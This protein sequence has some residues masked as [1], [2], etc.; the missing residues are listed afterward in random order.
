MKASPVQGEVGFAQQNSGGLS[1]HAADLQFL[2][3]DSFTIPRYAGAPFAQGSLFLFGAYAT[4]LLLGEPFIVGA[5]R[6]F[7]LLGR[8]L[9]PILLFL[10]IQIGLQ[11][12]RGR[13]LVHCFLAL[14]SPHIDFR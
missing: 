10:L 4:A 12:Q 6:Q 7:P 1:A 9:N 5:S 11:D 3:N 14:L 8:L 2:Q 13:K